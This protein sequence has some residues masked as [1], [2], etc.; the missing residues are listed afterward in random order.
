MYIYIFALLGTSVCSYPA[1]NILWNNNL[2]IYL[3]LSFLISLFSTETHP[4]HTT[5]FLSMTLKVFSYYLL[6]FAFQVG[7]CLCSFSRHPKDRLLFLEIPLNVCLHCKSK[8]EV[9][10]QV[11]PAL[12][13]YC[14]YTDIHPGT[15]WG[16]AVSGTPWGGVRTLTAR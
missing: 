16:Q 8:F 5:L 3:L 1:L 14:F 9:V 15:D 11:K 10:L 4:S 7:T 6:R 13:L 2:N 12:S